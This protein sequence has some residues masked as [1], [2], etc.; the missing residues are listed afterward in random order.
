MPG[1]SDNPPQKN[2]ECFGIDL[3]NYDTQLLRKSG[4]LNLSWLMAVY[5][6]FPQKDKFFN[7]Y[8]TKLAG[9]D[10]LRKQIEAGMTEAAIRNSWEPALSQFKQTRKKYLLYN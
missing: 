10:Q 2:V 6:K 7:A 4:K 8:F 9:T 1:I 3:R 5:Q